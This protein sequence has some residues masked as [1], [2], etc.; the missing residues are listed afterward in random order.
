[1][2]MGIAEN[3]QVQNEAFS[4]YVED[5]RKHAQETKSTFL[6]VEPFSLTNNINGINYI[7][8]VYI[9]VVFFPDEE[10]YK[11]FQDFGIPQKELAWMK[12]IDFYKEQFDLLAHENI[13]VYKLEFIKHLM[14]HLSI[15]ISN[16]VLKW[17]EFTDGT[18]AEPITAELRNA[19]RR[20]NYGMGRE[21]AYSRKKE[22][23]NS[24]A[25]EF[26]DLEEMNQMKKG[27]LLRLMDGQMT[28]DFYTT[29]LEESFPY[30]STVLRSNKFLLIIMPL[31]KEIFK[32]RKL[33]EIEDITDLQYAGKKI[34]TIQA[35]FLRKW[36]YKA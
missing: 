2:K 16:D 19:K 12:S 23:L 26:A 15:N 32:N 36:I 35:Q 5:L 31:F 30:S 18:K 3:Y 7:T 9:S 4:N 24:L 10:I 21:Y 20:I 1:M 6:S 28:R 25:K 8:G 27:E 34:E 11:K 22:I 13:I 29:W 14:V 17:A 33:P